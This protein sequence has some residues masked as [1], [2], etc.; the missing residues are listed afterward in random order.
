MNS[1]P[2]PVPH[3]AA[4]LQQ[5]QEQTMTR[6]RLHDRSGR[7]RRAPPVLLCLLVLL[8]AWGPAAAAASD[9]PEA[10]V[11][12][13]GQD[14]VD[15][16][17]S[18]R[19]A[20]EDRQK[21]LQGIFVEAFDTTTIARFVMG[22]HW[23][24]LGEDERKRYLEIFPAYVASIYATRFAEYGGEK[25]EVLKAQPAPG[26]QTLVETAISGGDQKQPVAVGIRVSKDGGAF[27]MIDVKV[28][29]VSLL[30]TK[31]DEFG[32]FLARNEPDELI[33]R[34]AKIAEK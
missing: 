4:V 18:T 14:V 1:D 8:T 16:L 21:K 33:E 29:G 5:A 19:P 6:P 15:V 27:R 9:T 12:K 24:R 34:L 25:F 23:R 10:F 17:K 31:R 13:V 3:Q 7:R 30:V 26:G 28:E 32:A 11:G 2:T 20:S 22:R